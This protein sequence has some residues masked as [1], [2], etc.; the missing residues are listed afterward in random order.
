MHSPLLKE[1]GGV[2]ASTAK[3]DTSVGYTQVHGENM[4]RFKQQ[5]LI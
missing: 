1:S 2:C 4:L 5:V 3:A